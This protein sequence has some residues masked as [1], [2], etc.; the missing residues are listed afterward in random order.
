MRKTIFFLLFI[1]LWGFSH[2][3]Q[4]ST[5]ALVK[6]EQGVWT[7]HVSASLSA[8]QAVLADQKINSPEE[9]QKSLIQWARKSIHI[10]VGLLNPILLEQGSVYLGHQTDVKFTLKGMPSKVESFSIEN[11]ILQQ[12]SGHAMVFKVIYPASESNQVVLTSSNDFS[13]NVLVKPTGIFIEPKPGFTYLYLLLIF[14][15]ILLCIY[16]LKRRS[17]KG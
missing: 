8:F 10:S 7:V 17:T 1:P 16:L 5:F 6:D 15:F 14:P 12:L 3:S 13:A 4:L 9:F 2:S 11:Q